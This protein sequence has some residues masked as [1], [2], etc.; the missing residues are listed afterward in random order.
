MKQ[1]FVVFVLLIPQLFLSAQQELPFKAIF[2]GD[3]L[4][5]TTLTPAGK[6][7]TGVL[8]V[9]GSGPTDRDGANPLGVHF[10]SYKLL[11]E[12]LTQKGFLTIRYDKRGIGESKYGYRIAEHTGM[13]HSIE[14]VEAIID[15]MKKEYP[16]IK[17]WVLIGHSEGAL[18]GAAAIVN[19]PVDVYVSLSGT[20]VDLLT[21]I[22]K[23]LKERLPES[24]HSYF[25]EPIDSLR[26]GFTVS[27]YPPALANVFA[28]P[29]QPYLISSTRYA[30]KDIL[31]GLKMPILIVNGGSD[32][33]IKNEE[34]ECLKAAQPKAEL[35]I[36]DDLNHVM[37]ASAADMN[38]NIKSYADAAGEIHPALLTKLV[39]FIQTN[40]GKGKNKRKGN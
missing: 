4:F 7:E 3:T 31:P 30:A 23:Q 18:L 17:K 12:A 10:K 25:K 6:Y 37:K 39:S 24:S 21:T 35:F 11:A 27:K 29:S 40:T 19:H 8:I 33:Q 22:E 5:G 26:A 13:T 1:L 38:T 15:A 16:S 36:I 14:D 32:I 28:P 2:K 20:C 34:A 9:P